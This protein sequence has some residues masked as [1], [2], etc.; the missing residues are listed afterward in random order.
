MIAEFSMTLRSG[1]LLVV[2]LSGLIWCMTAGGVSAQQI[3]FLPGGREMGPP[4]Y[5]T[6]RIGPLYSHFTFTED[7]GIRYTDGTLGVVDFINGSQRGAYLKDGID[8]PMITTMSLRNYLQI[9]K[10]MDLDISVW[11][12]YEH[13]PLKT[14]DDV[15]IMNL[16]DPALTTSLMFEFYPTDYIRLK[17]Y[18]NPSYLISYV[19]RRGTEDLYGGLRY[20]RFQ[21]DAGLDADILLERDM[22][23]ALTLSRSDVVGASEGFADQEQTTYSGSAAYEYQLT[24][25]FVT[26]VRASYQD[27]DYVSLS[28]GDYASRAYGVFANAELSAVS[29]ASAAV[30]YG[31][32]K[33]AATNSASSAIDAGGVQGL[34]SFETEFWKDTVFQASY[35]RTM[36]PGFSYGVESGGA[37]RGSLKWSDGS[38]SVVLSSEVDDINVAGNDGIGYR[39]WR[40]VLQVIYPL[41][42]DCTLD[43]SSTYGVRNV[44]P[45]S[46]LDTAGVPS[47]LVNGY[48]TWINKVRITQALMKQLSL[49]AYLEYVIRSSSSAS[50]AYDRFNGGMSLIYVYEY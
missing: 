41:A 2:C 11:A 23:V 25:M 26:G 30:G 12:R 40:N 29:K 39:D 46:G 14:Q 35:T 50:L 49:S 20:R 42:S 24:P 7:I 28:R 19:D 34:V 6:F 4:D 38:S 8:F 32:G 9:S 17:L 48:D 13:Y 36:R 27:A 22:N 5:A 16:T 44:S 47:E 37:I 45:P 18:E 1:R 33:T 3:R 43:V 15:F 10:Y 21:N 31:T